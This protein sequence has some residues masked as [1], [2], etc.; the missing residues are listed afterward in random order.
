MYREISAM[1]PGPTT[2]P[3][4]DVPAALIVTPIFSFEANKS[5]FFISG[6]P[7]GHATAVGCSL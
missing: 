1:I 6:A 5:I 2:W 4:R 7:F 3:A